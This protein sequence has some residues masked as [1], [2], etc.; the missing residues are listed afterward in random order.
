MSQKTFRDLGIPFP[1]FDAPV[2]EAAEYMGIG[3]CSLCQKDGVHCFELEDD[4]I[5]VPC[6]YC[7]SEVAPNEDY[8][9]RRACHNCGNRVDIVELD[10][11]APLACYGCLRAGRVA[12]TKGTEFG[13]IR[14]EDAMRGITHGRPSINRSDFDLVPGSNGWVGVKLPR[15]TML[16]LLRMPTYLTFQCDNWLFCC[17]EP[18]I[19]VGPWSREKFSEIAANGD[20]REFFH[21]VVRDTVD[22]L[23]D[24]FNAGVYVFRCST[25]GKHSAHWDRD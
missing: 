11:E 10:E 12:L 23:W 24:E 7:G 1:L 14:H 6:P 19:Y 18:M 20:G 21:Q 2:S 5:I 9:I 16:E 25:C 13:M 15:A 3:R 17:K 8:P 4:E 22:G